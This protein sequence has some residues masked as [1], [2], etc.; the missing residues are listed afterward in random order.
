MTFI[1]ARAMPSSPHSARSD[2]AIDHTV[3]VPRSGSGWPVM[4]VHGMH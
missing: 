1:A 2:L 3:F 4:I